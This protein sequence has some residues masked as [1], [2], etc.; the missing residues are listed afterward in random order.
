MLA[1]R[2][3]NYSSMALNIKLLLDKRRSKKDGTYPLVMRILYSRK[4]INVALGYSLLESDWNE[5]DEKIKATT[6]QFEG[7]ARLNNYL[8]KQRVKAYDLFTKLQDSDE[9]KSLNLTDIKHM[10]VGDTYDSQSNVFEF[11]D[12]E[13]FQLKKARKD[14][15]AAV[16]KTL[17][18]K[19][20]SHVGSETLTFHQI[21][22][23]FLK[24]LETTHYA[25]GAKVGSLSVYMRTLRALY[26]K[27]IKAGVVEKESYPFDDYKIKN[28]K[29]VRK[30]LSLDGFEIFKE[31]KL[32]RG[33]SK[34]EAKKLFMASFYLRG[35]NWMDM[36]YLKLSDFDKGR[37][38]VNYVR[39]KTNEPF[40]IKVH[41]KLREMLDMFLSSD[42]RKGDFVFPIIPKEA[43][44]AKYNDL[45]RG[46]RERVNKRLKEIA[47]ECDIEPFTIYAARH[48]YATMGKRKGVPTAVIQESLGH[49]TEAMT[50]TYLDS[51]EN[52]VVDD[53]DDL[54]MG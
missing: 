40:N 19:L 48:T 5:R 10:L 45:I 9:L 53:Y 14:G 7:V 50:Q 51:F 23:S 42:N 11:I 21:T 49:S 22:F 34:E 41:P 18:N 36:A 4:S 35:M 17:R 1:N 43:V 25:G 2:L 38:R 29:P 16:Y 30:S 39:R 24:K 46:K 20:K 12:S 6:K 13:I 28:G 31:T 54:I 8:H 37:D 3:Q 44:T 15:N 32:P 27:A 52:K 47:R 33:S 26:N